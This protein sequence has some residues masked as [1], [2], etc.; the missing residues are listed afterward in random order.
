M[1]MLFIYIIALIRPHSAC[2]EIPLIT[3]NLS[4]HGG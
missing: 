3:I 1:M 2:I 4:P